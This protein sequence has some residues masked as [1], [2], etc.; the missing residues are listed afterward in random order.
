LER[1]AGTTFEARQENTFYRPAWQEN[2]LRLGQEALTKHA[3]VM[4][5]A[6]KFPTR[7]IQ[8]ERTSSWNSAT[9]EWISKIEKEERM[10][11]VG[12]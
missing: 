8:F 10:T 12:T 4:P 9:T 3:K 1:P 2:L 6:R 7:L 11:G 5:V